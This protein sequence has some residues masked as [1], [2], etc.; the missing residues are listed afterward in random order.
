MPLAI[1]L[2][3]DTVQAKRSADWRRDLQLSRE[4]VHVGIY[5]VIRSVK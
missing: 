3:S 1:K 2:F 4:E 5:G